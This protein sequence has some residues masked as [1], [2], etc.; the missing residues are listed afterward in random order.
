MNNKLWYYVVSEDNKNKVI[1][2]TVYTMAPTKLK[3]ME[4][5]LKMGLRAKTKIVSF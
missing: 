2:G 1:C 5:Q 4:A 3:A